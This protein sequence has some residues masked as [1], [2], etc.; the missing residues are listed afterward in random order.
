MLSNTFVEG[1]KLF[2]TVIKLQERVIFQEKLFY[3]N[4]VCKRITVYETTT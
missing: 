1:N 2:M 3:T 4:D